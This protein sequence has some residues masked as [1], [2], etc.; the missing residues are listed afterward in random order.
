MK[1]TLDCNCCGAV[2][3]QAD[4]DG[5]FY[6]DDETVCP[7]CAT[8]C[9]VGIDYDH[10]LVYVVEDGHCADVGQMKCDGSCGAPAEFVGEP[11]NT[12]DCERCNVCPLPEA[13]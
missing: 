6:E 9:M 10:N 4:D 3:F 13:P 1:H 8:I 2:V 12:Y 7:D 5:L 11:G